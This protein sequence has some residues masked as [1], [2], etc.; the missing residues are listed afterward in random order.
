MLLVRPDPFEVD[1]L[2]L[3]NGATEAQFQELHVAA[4]GI[5]WCAQF[6]AHGGEEL[7]LG[8]VRHFSCTS[9]FLGFVLLTFRIC[10]G[11]TFGFEQPLP[12]TDVPEK[13][14]EAPCLCRIRVDFDPHVGDIGHVIVLLEV[15]SYSPS[16]SRVDIGA[17][18]LSRL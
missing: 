9:C 15:D 12:F 8:F 5:Q 6:M 16:P 17:R 10:A 7:A 2:F 11:H 4:D 3:G 1:G 18:I 14:V 13:D